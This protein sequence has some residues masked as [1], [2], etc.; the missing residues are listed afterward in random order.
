MA[1]QNTQNQLSK[2]QRE[3]LRDIV[4]LY[5][6]GQVMIHLHMPE[7]EIKTIHDLL[8]EGMLITHRTALPGIWTVMPTMKALRHE[9]PLEAA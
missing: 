1:S 6:D 2:R 7:H 5:V 9:H 3:L 4:D 8:A